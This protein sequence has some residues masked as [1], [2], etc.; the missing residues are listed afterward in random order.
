MTSLRTATLI[1]L[2]A[3]L[4]TACAR[5]APRGGAEGGTLSPPSLERALIATEAGSGPDADRDPES[6]RALRAALVRLVA[7]RGYVR[8]ERVLEAMRRV[9]RHLFV[10]GAPLEEAYGD[11][12]LGIGAGQTISQPS[13]V[14]EMTEALELRGTERVLEIGTGSG[15]QAAVLSVLARQVYTIEIVKELGVRAEARLRDLGYSNVQVRVGDGYAGWAEEAP[16]DRVILTAAPPEVPKALLDQL[17]EGGVLVAPVGE[18]H[19]TQWLVRIRKK[20]GKLAR[21]RL[22]LV[23]FVPMVPGR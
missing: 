8:S 5:A 10:P 13:V 21:E 20:D 2:L 4:G 9:P 6:A 12:P 17:A 15:Y 11:W 18:E 19:G 14:G 3:A 23:R 7:A 22:S 16:F 1:L